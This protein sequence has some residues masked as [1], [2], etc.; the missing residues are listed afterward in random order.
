MALGDNHT[1]EIPFLRVRARLLTGPDY[2]GCI[3]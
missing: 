3:S 1:R 2:P